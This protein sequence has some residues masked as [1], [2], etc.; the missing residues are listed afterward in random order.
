MRLYLGNKNYS[1][2]SLRAGLLIAQAGIPC[3]T[4]LLSFSD[5]AERD[6]KFRRE[7]FKVTPAGRVPTLV[8]GEVVVWDS[9]AIAEYVAER[10]P[11][12][13][14]WPEDRAARARARS[15]CAEMH[16]GFMGVRSD[17]PMNIEF[18]APEIG[19]RVLAEKPQTRAD[20]ARLDA[21]ISGELAHSGGPMLFGTFGIADA[22]F[23][24]VASRIR[25]YGLPVSEATQAWVERIHQ[26]PAMQAWV[27]DA[28]EEHDWVVFDEPYRDPPTR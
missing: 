10:F 14:L 23:A 25:S 27:R 28:L 9:L 18:V 15:L 7:I 11:E 21:I 20:L 16:S 6:S 2:W 3:E 17:F 12:K 8:D 26:L 22:Y 13:K 19:P 5:T 4:V 1:S 24:P